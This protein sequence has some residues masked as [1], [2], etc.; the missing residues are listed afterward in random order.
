MEWVVK[1][2]R[3]RSGEEEKGGDDDEMMES[4]QVHYM[5]P[6][7]GQRHRRCFRS[8]E[9]ERILEALQVRYKR[10]MRTYTTRIAA[11]TRARAHT[12]GACES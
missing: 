2:V 12:G 3:G 11:H 7:T 5:C 8:G 10:E 9:Y 4:F 6:E 1:V